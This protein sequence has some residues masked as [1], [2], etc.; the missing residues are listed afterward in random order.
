MTDI[1]PKAAKVAASRDKT[2]DVLIVGGG[3]AGFSA[4]VKA[5][6]DGATVIIIEKTP[7]IGGAG[8]VGAAGCGTLG[9]GTDFQKAAGVVDTPERLYEDLKLWD[10]KAEPELL[11]A[12]ADHAATVCHFLRDLG[13][14][15]THSPAPSPDFGSP[16]GRTHNV[17]G[18]GPALYQVMRPAFEKAGGTLL[19]ETKGAKLLKNAKGAIVGVLA[20]DKDGDFA[21][22]AKATILTCGGWLANDEMMTKYVSP[23]AL[24]AMHRGLPTDTGD[25]V[26]MGLEVGA[27]TRAMDRVHAYI[28]VAPFPLP[29]PFQPWRIAAPSEATAFGQPKQ[30]LFG[31]MQD[32]FSHCIVVNIRGERFA[33][34]TK[35]RLGEQMANEILKQPEVRAYVIAD[36]TLYETYW[37]SV[38]EEGLRWA[39]L[40][41]PPAQI[42]S[43]ETVEDLARKLGM[44]P[45]VLASTVREYNAAVAEGSAHLM[46]IPKSSSHPLDIYGQLGMNML[47]KMET[48][49]FYAVHVTAGISHPHGGI[50]TNGQGQV[51][52]RDRNVIPGLYSA[53]DTT[54]IWH[55]NYGGG[56][57]SAL[58]QGYIAGT[59]AAAEAAQ[60]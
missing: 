30:H 17:V 42:E 23:G 13:V 60:Q 20:H 6:Q 31:N 39:E 35:P 47:H 9:G 3:T 59:N 26:I 36:K 48:P 38:A 15:F 44:N 28:H 24:Y 41:Y 40:G 18:R 46:R 51:T 14:K 33:D 56:V 11:K 27:G 5:A 19:T 45:G 55:G 52:D 32:Q 12:Y 10:A 2:C 29:Y 34:E 43:A 53:G 49:P 1:D 8:L 4:G 21:I 22:N 7:N 57:P 58:V 37:K 16:I 54:V 25:G 50:A